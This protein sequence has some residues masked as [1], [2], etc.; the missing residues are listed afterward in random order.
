M[1]VSILVM[2]CAS[3][4]MRPF[5]FGDIM[6]VLL[7]IC[8]SVLDMFLRI[9]SHASFHIWRYY[10]SSHVLRLSSHASL[11]IWRPFLV[12][13]SLT[14]FPLILVAA[15][16][17]YVCLVISFFP[18]LVMVQIIYSA[19]FWSLPSLC[20]MLQAMYN[21]KPRLLWFDGSQW[22]GCL[23]CAMHVTPITEN[24]C[25]FLVVKQACWQIWW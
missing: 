11:H 20:D 19:R 6:E 25:W 10:Y 14:V 16:I 13:R 23:S 12:I 17:V 4:V 18:V 24:Y 3:L 5:I 9:S 2:F 21:G 1:R 8:V 15:V 7:V 22:S